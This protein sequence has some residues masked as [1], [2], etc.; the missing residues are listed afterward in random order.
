[1]KVLII[2]DIHGNLPALE[3]VLTA[4]KDADLVVSLG[5][6]VNYGPWSNECVDLLE[7]LPNKILI[8]GNHEDAFIS[9]IYPGENLVVKSF[10]NFCY[11]KFD[12]KSQIEN[13]LKNWEMNNFFFTHTLNNEYIFSD[14]EITINANTFIGH[15]HSMFIKE[16][17]GYTLVNVG[18][19]GQNRKNINQINYVVWDS[20]TNKIDLI[21][22]EFNAVKLFNEMRIKGYPEICMNYLLSK[23]IKV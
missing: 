12:R 10:F 6:V 22:K 13:Y 9:G 15:S 14:T 18:S 2:S 5:D 16:N 1:M 23:Q 4:E 21:S 19:V 11:P 17:M 7:T 8:K 20:E 3:Y